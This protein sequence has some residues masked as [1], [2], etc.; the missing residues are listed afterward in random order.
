MPLVQGNQ[1]HRRGHARFAGLAL[2]RM[3]ITTW[4]LSLFVLQDWQETRFYKG[5]NLDAIIKV[6]GAIVS[7]KQAQVFIEVTSPHLVRTIEIWKP[8]KDNRDTRLASVSPAA[9]E[10]RR[11]DAPY[12]QLVLQ[13][14][15]LAMEL[16]IQRN[17]PGKAAPD[18][19]QTRAEQLRFMRG[20]L[21]EI[22]QR[23]PPVA[24][25]VVAVWDGKFK[26][27]PTRST[28]FPFIVRVYW[29]RGGAQ[30]KES[31]WR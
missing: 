8:A 16:D 17:G 28:E 27:N 13:N 3:L 25:H 6:T 2:R 1:T 26:K 22:T 29:D 4:L 9:E 12:Q 23:P 5:G 31:V 7:D 21:E 14:N 24:F 18:L 10:Q 20:S 30:S 15:I 19:L 11:A